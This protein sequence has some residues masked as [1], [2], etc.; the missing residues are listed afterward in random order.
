MSGH[1][2]RCCVS[3]PFRCA[4]M[5]G[6]DERAGLLLRTCTKRRRE[7][8]PPLVSALVP[9]SLPCSTRRT[10]TFTVRRDP[11]ERVSPPKAFSCTTRTLLA[12]YMDRS[13]AKVGAEAGCRDEKAVEIQA[14]LGSRTVNT[15]PLPGS[16]A[17]LTRPLCNSVMRATRERPTPCPRVTAVLSTR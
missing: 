4:Q 16:E 7:G 3:G 8:R 9:A 13:A 15:E 6:C 1:K 2:C 5:Y 17:R 12:S 10:C 11:L 14:A